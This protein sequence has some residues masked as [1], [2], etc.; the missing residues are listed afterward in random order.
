MGCGSQHDTGVVI[1]LGYSVHQMSNGD[2]IQAVPQDEELEA[3]WYRDVGDDD[4]RGVSAFKPQGDDW[5][6]V[7]AAANFI[8][9]EPLETELRRGVDAALR[10]VP[11]VTSVLEEDREVWIAEGSPQA[12][13]LILA[14]ANVVDGLADRDM[15]QIRVAGRVDP[16]SVQG[17]VGLNRE[18]ALQRAAEAGIA[19]V[20]VSEVGTRENLMADVRSDR[21]SLLMANGYVVKAAF[22]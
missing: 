2:V 18:Q 1:L 17:Y 6:V 13:L 15:K 10:S 21:L 7:V 16:T 11:G 14:V 4:L 20:R 19:D 12:D 8:R 22:L 9:D 5:R 3:E